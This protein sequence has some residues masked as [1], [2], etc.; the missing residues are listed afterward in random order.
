MT[1]PLQ[2]PLDKS[3][4]TGITRIIV[5]IPETTFD[6]H[7]E[8][9]R[10]CSPFF[11]RLFKDHSLQEIQTNPVP[12]PHDDPDLFGDLVSWIYRGTISKYFLAEDTD[13][14]LLRLWVLAA[15]FEM[16]GLQ[17]HVASH[18]HT[19]PGGVFDQAKINFVYENTRPD[20]PL[21][22]LVV[23]MWVRNGTQA[24]CSELLHSL[25]HTFLGDLCG[26]LFERKDTSSNSVMSVADFAKRYHVQTH[27]ETLAIQD[28]P[29]KRLLENEVK[30]ESNVPQRATAAQ[31][32]RRKILTPKRRITPSPGA[33]RVSSDDLWKKRRM[34]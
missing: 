14:F 31:M 19:Q 21:R 25:P 17:N 20:S 34:S 3:T 18:Y 4:L 24:G 27:V 30:E 26:A 22:R 1:A 16:P 6:V 10:S 11:D 9:L 33:L 23:E 12:L 15:R 29:R 13:F 7:I 28:H 8:L 32:E 2:A 5:G